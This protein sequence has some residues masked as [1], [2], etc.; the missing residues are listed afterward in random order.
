M[1]QNCAG[2]E[3]RDLA[4]LAYF[5]ATE[6]NY[7]LAR[8]TAMQFFNRAREAANQA[9]DANSRKGLEDLMSLHDTV[10]AE[11]TKADAST[12]GDLH[13]LFMRSRQSTAWRTV[14][15]K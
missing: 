10:M 4:G 7:G 2:A 15:P 5:Q 6:K 3:L 13:V 14:G 12:V 9:T 11:L 1:R 8:D